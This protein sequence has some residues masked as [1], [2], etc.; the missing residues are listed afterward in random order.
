MRQTTRAVTSVSSFQY[1]HI[2]SNNNNNNNNTNKHLFAT[3]IISD[4][5]NVMDTLY[6]DTE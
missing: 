6:L 4:I 3:L 5:S 1:H 2:T